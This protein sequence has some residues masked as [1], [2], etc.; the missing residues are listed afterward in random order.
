VDVQSLRILLNGEEKTHLFTT[1]ASGA[2]YQ[3]TAED[4]LEKGENIVVATISNRAGL[5]RT[6]ASA[7]TVDITAAEGPDETPRS[8]IEVGFFAPPIVSQDAFHAPPTVIS[9]DLTQFG[10]ALFQGPSSTFAPVTDVAV[11]PDYV[12]GPGDNL[13]VYM[14]GL[15]EDQFTLLVD[16][17][18]A[19]FMPK[20]GAM[21]VAGLTFSDAERIV[22][23]RLATYFS[24]FQVRLAM[25]EL[26]A[27][28]VY[29]VG[30]VTRPGAYTLSALATMTNALYS[31]GGPT[32]LGTLRTVQLR[33]NEHLVATLDLY[34]FLLRGDRASDLRLMSGDTVFVPPIGPVAGIAGAVK[35]PAIYEMVR[36]MRVSDLVAMAGGATPLAYLRRVQLE[37]IE[38]NS[39]KVIIDLD[40]STYYSR[41]DRL[42]D[43]P[44]QDGDLLKVLPIDSRVYNTVT[45]DGY[46]KHPGEYEFQPGI[47]VSELVT[48]DRLL[49]EAFVDQ[50]EVVRQRPD[51]RRQILTVDLRRAWSGEP[52]QD[53]ILQPLDKVVVRSEFKSVQV[54]TLEGEVMRPGTYTIGHGE[55]LSSVLKRAGGFTEEAY[56]RGAVF[57]R[58]SIREVETEQLDRFIL[59]QQEAILQ[60]SARAG[61]ASLE[62]ASGSGQRASIQQQTLQ[63]RKELLEVLRS[64]VLLGRVVVKL[65]PLERFEGSASDVLLEAGDTLIVPKQPSSVLVVG[66][67]R[68][69]TAVIY[70]EG[71]DVEY[72]LNR[73]G[74]L[75]KEADEDEIYIVKADGSAMAGFAQIQDV[76]RGDTI[77]APPD[78]DADVPT[79]LLVGD[80]A[81]IAGGFGVLALG[82]AAAF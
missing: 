35:R 36:P 77:V 50:V 22:E 55:R 61:A 32:K 56:L 48:R 41:G 19:I 65:K 10:Y 69:P 81:K 67:V 44:V 8:P 74:G 49:P 31:A 60:E 4:S 82:I 52:G 72:Y 28:K 13:V 47:R 34:N 23:R 1:S 76:E 37:R 12:I 51:F 26:R 70:R 6:A 79:L 57:I 25:G 59:V 29:V 43:I 80:L 64:K 3:V 24:G 54:V 15:V 17:N 75:S 63:Q 20:V 2:S 18:G 71:N 5:T 21:P 45:L 9:R 42:Y 27:V 68:N 58:E 7:F 78:L 11:G 38:E 16:R 46:V 14:W 62:V 66:S 73:A 33:R 39:R 30:E 40:L 53:V